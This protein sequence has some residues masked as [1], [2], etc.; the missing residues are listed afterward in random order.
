MDPQDSPSWR[1]APG[2]L[3]ALLPC[4]DPQVLNGHPDDP[5][6]RSTRRCQAS[7]TSGCVEFLP[8]PGNCLHEC[9]CPASKRRQVV[10][11]VTSMDVQGRQCPTWRRSR[12]RR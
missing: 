1:R 5:F 4:M 10:F 12:G 6:A 11:S 2:A 9:C 3:E 8:L 7:T